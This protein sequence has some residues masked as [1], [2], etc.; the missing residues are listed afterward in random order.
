MVVKQNNQIIEFLR[1][2]ELE[3]IDNSSYETNPNDEKY[4]K[5]MALVEDFKESSKEFKKFLKEIEEHK[6]DI[7]PGQFG[8][9]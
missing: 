4:S 1:S 6:D 3:I 8:E 2:L 5:L 9:S 7:T